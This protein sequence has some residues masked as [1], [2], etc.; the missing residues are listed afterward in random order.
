[1]LLAA[2]TITMSLKGEIENVIGFVQ[3]LPQMSAEILRLEDVIEQPRDSIIT[4][5]PPLSSWTSN[6]T[7]LSGKIQINNLSFGYIPIK[8]SLIENLNINIEPG[9]RFA[10]VGSSGS[11][12][13][14]I[15]KLISGLYMPTNGS[16][17][18]D[19]LRLT[20][21]PREVAVSSIA[22]VQQSINLYGCSVRDNLTMWNPQIN[23]NILEEA[24]ADAQILDTVL[25]LPDGF[26][27][28][29]KEGANNLSGGQRQRLE[30]ARALVQNPSILI[31]DEA[32][33]AL[34][35]TSE[36]LVGQAL[37]RRGCT[38]IIVAHRLST[39]RDADSIIVLNRG[40]V[41][42]NGRHEDLKNEDGSLYQKLLSY[43]S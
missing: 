41:V 40:K 15:S 26:D 3:G 37:R 24:C 22:M 36:Q 5:A 8:P 7:R 12:K 2:Q 14:T 34:D 19:G 6:R 32:T 13:S 27:T 33:S 31:L 38:Q 16:I 29:L 1:M 9:Q 4:Q 42:Q 18:Y 21:I 30:I 35:P 43:N 17:L 10:F 25:A 39:I 11:G 28:V 23:D 20:E